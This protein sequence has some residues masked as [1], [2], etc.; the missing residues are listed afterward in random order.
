[1][2]DC[3][4]IYLHGFLSSA[5]S[6]KGLWLVNKNTETKLTLFDEIITISYPNKSV[7]ESVMVIEAE[8]KKQLK[9]NKKVVLLGSSLGGFYA[10]Y[11]AQIYQLPYIMI[12]PALNLLPVFKV[13]L[14]LHTNPTTGE[15]V[16]INQS[17]ISNLLKYDVANPNKTIAA[18]LLIDLDDEVIDVDFA[19]QRYKHSDN[20]PCFKAKI[21]SGGDHRFIH[22][23]EAWY[24]IQDFIST[25]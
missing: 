1:M 22:M 20:A 9:K 25:L 6:E 19:I 23:E 15:V 17:Y 8:I 11:F 5:K 21:Y 7:A 10:Q 4:G 3:I 14:G 13:N 16:N 18:L 12:N 2:N 24:E